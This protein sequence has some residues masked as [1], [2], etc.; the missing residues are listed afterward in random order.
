MKKSLL[1]SIISANIILS[2]G[3]S[4]VNLNMDRRIESIDRYLQEQVDY[5]NFNGNVLIAEKG[6]T[7]YQK[8]FGFSDFNKQIPL[9]DSSIFELAS[10]GKQFTA[11]CI[12]ML[13]KQGLLNLNDSL[14]KFFPELPYYNIKI[15]H[16]LTHT[17]GLPNSYKLFDNKW[18][19]KKIAFNDDVIRLLSKEKPA[20]HFRPG[21]KWEYSNTG[22]DLL[23]SIIEKVSGLS[24]KDCMAKN[25]FIPLQ[26]A[27]TRIYNTRRSG[28][29]I[30]NYAY[31]YVWSD[32]LNRYI[33]PD[34]LPEYNYV[35]FLDGIQGS[36]LINSTTNDLL[37][38]TTFLFDNKVQA[39]TLIQKLLYPYTLCDF[40]ATFGGLRYNGASRLYYG[41]GV[42]L[43]NNEFG[44]FAYHGGGW[45]GY[46][47]EIFRCLTDGIT[48][49]VL[50]NNESYATPNRSALV[51][52]INNQPLV[53]SKS[54]FEQP[55]D[56]TI[57][58]VFVGSFTNKNY[59]YEIIREKE[60]LFMINPRSGNRN[61]LVLESYNKLFATDFDFRF[62]L[63]KDG[64][65]R[66]EYYQ[67]L[68]GNYR[69]E[70]QKIK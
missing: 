31:G 41:Y 2:F 70:M 55:I 20:I 26:M 27:N 65:N 42:F 14:K 19:H 5:F 17:S 66:N 68:F 35:Y 45:P 15:H 48:I 4:N 21:E 53:S 56:T 6:K 23:A 50:S 52:I 16:L 40:A 24:F 18:D 13:E 28:E 7:I 30:D 22:Y 39:D 33:L 1:I 25:I 67:V 3:Q 34:S 37:K 51:K 61:K 32:S 63:I 38:W 8:S 59:S 9:N 11:M 62:E 44:D 10:I 46:N 29:I 49:I 69:S 47:T 57:L 60:D 54:Y 36:G 64:E 43:G 12:L 58:D